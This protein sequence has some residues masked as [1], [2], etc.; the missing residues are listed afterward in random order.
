MKYWIILS[1][2]IIAGIAGI[3]LFFLGQDTYTVPLLALSFLGLI[4]IIAWG[5]KNGMHNMI[6][7][8]EVRI[9]DEELKRRFKVDSLYK[10]MTHTDEWLTGFATGI[11]FFI[12]NYLSKSTIGPEEHMFWDVMVK[13][14]TL[15]D[16]GKEEEE[17]Y[18][19]FMLNALF[20]GSGITEQEYH[21]IHSMDLD[22]TTVDTLS[23]FI[24]SDLTMEQTKA[25]MDELSKQLDDATKA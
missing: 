16:F 21:K 12:R 22:P 13:D 10:N 17:C 14:K 9:K 8:E 2:P 7:M 24:Y 11:S 25:E 5:L 18:R 4:S 6:M 1:L 15:C 19:N 3:V 23:R 20:R